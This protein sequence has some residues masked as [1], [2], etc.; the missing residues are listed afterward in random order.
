[1]GC[2]VLAWLLGVCI[3]AAG[4]AEP[5]LARY[6]F[7]RT[8]MSIPIKLVLYAPD[9]ATANRAAGAAFDR[10]AQLDDILSDYEAESELNR[11]CDTA[12]E[13]RAVPVSEDL[14][15]VLSYGQ[16]IAE[17]SGGAFDATI[18]PVV[19][20]WRRAR[21]TKE[22]P[23]AAKLREALEL[24]GYKNVR[25]DP[26]HRAIELKK[27]GMRLDLGGIA[28]GYIGDQALAVLRKQGVPRAII[29]AGGDLRLGD[30]PPGKP[31]WIIGVAPPCL[32]APPTQYLSLANR[33]V[34]TSG[35]MFQYVDIGGKR[36]SHVIDPKTGLGLT[37][38]RITTVVAPNGI[39]SDGLSKVVAVLEPEKSF[40]LIDATPGVAA[41]VLSDPDGKIQTRCSARWSALPVSKPEAVGR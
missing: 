37:D 30:P 2:T 7:D 16:S 13:G 23:S 15:T 1:M 32:D 21:R 19:H 5:S 17:Q 25:L 41:M 35:D 27:R 39:T 4:P 38:R 26:E 24:V 22:M 12:G 6:Q 14:W 36:Y 33:G 34:S 3:P 31:G 9:G 18:K 28:K 20:L 29:H 40:P 8:I 10:I 11:L